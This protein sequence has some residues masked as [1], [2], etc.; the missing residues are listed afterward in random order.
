M[1]ANGTRR[2]R[3]AGIHGAQA[4]AF[5][6]AVADCTRAMVDAVFS[7]LARAGADPWLRGRGRADLHIHS[8]ASDGISS[9]EEILAAAE[10]VDWT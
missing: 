9:V 8:L 4:R 2:E 3:L 5:E 6:R 7:H 1:P 10:G